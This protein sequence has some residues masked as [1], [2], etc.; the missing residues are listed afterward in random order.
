MNERKIISSLHE[1]LIK[2]AAAGRAQAEAYPIGPLREALLERVLAVET[3][4]EAEG[5]TRPA[6]PAA[7]V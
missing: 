4:I 7:E 2:F 6:D 1:R 3:N 5:R